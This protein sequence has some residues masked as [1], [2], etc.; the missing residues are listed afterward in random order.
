M[1]T[2][3]EITFIEK[4]DLSSQLAIDNFGLNRWNDLPF[5]VRTRA[6]QS[7]QNKGAVV[8]NPNINEWQRVE[9]ERINEKIAKIIAVQKSASTDK[10][11]SL[12]PKSSTLKKAN[13]DEAT[14]DII[15]FVHHAPDFKPEDLIMSDVKWKYLV[16]NIM[17]GLNIMM[18]G[19][20]G[21]GKTVAAITAAKSLERPYYIFPMGSSQD[22]RAT[23]IGNTQFN[24]EDGTYFAESRFVHAIQEE[25]AVIILDEL[26]RANGEAWNILMPVLDYNQRTLQLDEKPG[27]PV[28]NVHPTVSFIATANVGFQYT[29]T[30]VMDRALKD[31]FVTIEMDLLSQQEESKLL[32][33][34]VPEVSKELIKAISNITSDIRTELKSDAPRISTQISTRVAIEIASLLRDG[35]TLPEAAEISIYPYYSDEGGAQSERVFIKQLVQKYIVDKNQAETLQ[36]EESMPF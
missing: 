16:R 27:S 13:L 19:D 35:F 18:V 33:Y 8:Y 21:M 15:N 32:S 22:P 5:T 24:K 25:N 20:S 6:G 2:S 31:R 4:V 9:H 30:R 28:I 26:S 1:N 17:R 11:K 14:T 10:K 23:L 12:A 3:N 7:F 36:P 34:K 29:S